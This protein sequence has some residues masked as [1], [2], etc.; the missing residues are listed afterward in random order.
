MFLVA[1]KTIDIYV[2]CATLNTSTTRQENEMTTLQQTISG[3]NESARKVFGSDVNVLVA[4]APAFGNEDVCFVVQGLRQ[5]E[6]ARDLLRFVRGGKI[7][8]S[9]TKFMGVTTTSTAVE[10]MTL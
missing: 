2:S 9:T 7:S 10:G 6:V 5:A 4:R 8:Q 1:Q 3:F